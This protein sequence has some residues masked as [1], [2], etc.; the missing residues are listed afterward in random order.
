M[1]SRKLKVGLFAGSTIDQFYPRTGEILKNIL[2]SEGV[3]C[4]YATNVTDSGRLLYLAGDEKGARYLGEQMLKYY[5]DDDYVVAADS[6]DVAYFRHFGSRLFHNT[7]CQEA[8]DLLCH[9]FIHATDFLAGV[10][11]Y[12]PAAVPFAHK[13]AVMDH[14][15]TLRDYGRTILGGKHSGVS[16]GLQDEPRQLL[17]MIPGLALVEMKQR[18]ACCGQ[19]DFFP[20]RFTPIAAELARRTVQDALD[21]GVEYLVSTESSCI[22]HLDAYCVQHRLPLKCRHVIDVLGRIN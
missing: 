20:Q 4:H 14:C 2:L 15:R 8:Y 21:M 10:L 3:D 17:R 18:E 1:P 6:G 7:A 16:E 13:V 11:D 9:R 12:H 5:A 19:A 22:L